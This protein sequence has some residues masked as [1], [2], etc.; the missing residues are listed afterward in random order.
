MKAT[1]SAL[2][3]AVVGTVMVA[4]QHQPYFITTPTPGEPVKAGTPYVL[5]L[6]KKK[7]KRGSLKYYIEQKSNNIFSTNN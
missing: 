3:F 1:I 7:T 2:V 5:Q 6:K 4:A